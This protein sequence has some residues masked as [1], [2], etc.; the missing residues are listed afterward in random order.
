M[1]G[2]FRLAY[3]PVFCHYPARSWVLVEMDGINFMQTKFLKTE[4]QNDTQRFGYVSIIPIRLSQPKSDF[5]PVEL[6]LNLQSDS[7]T[8]V[9][10]GN[11][12]IAKM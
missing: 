11:K 3:H 10:S 9:S 4:F 8:N 1:V 5:G 7:P 2:E 12:A 6:R